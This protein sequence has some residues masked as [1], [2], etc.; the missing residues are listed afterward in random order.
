MAS[1]RDIK[2]QIRALRSA[3]PTLNKTAPPTVNDENKKDSIDYGG[4]TVALVNDNRVVEE[5]KRKRR[6]TVRRHQSL[7]LPSKVTSHY[8]RGYDSVSYILS[9]KRQEAGRPEKLTLMSFNQLVEEKRCLQKVLMDFEKSYGRPQ[10]SEGRSIMRPIYDHYRN[11][12]KLLTTYEDRHKSMRNK[13]V[14]NML[15]ENS[16][17]SVTVLQSSPNDMLKATHDD[18]KDLVKSSS[19]Q[20]T[21]SLIP[22]PPQSLTPKPGTMLL[23]TVPIDDDRTPIICDSQPPRI[24]ENWMSDDKL[25]TATK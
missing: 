20:M 14:N 10:T 16:L 9:M 8:Q 13:S 15:K 5:D 17:F 21:E 19:T 11:V 1:L 4:S 3:K 7:L 25:V 12:K 6:G 18:N 2:K 22:K 24:I 23:P